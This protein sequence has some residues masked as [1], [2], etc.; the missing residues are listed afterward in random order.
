MQKFSFNHTKA[1]RHG[2]ICYNINDAYVGQSFHNYGEFSEGEVELFAQM[3]AEGDVVI[4]AGANI[5]AHTLWFARH[6]G[7]KGAVFAF[8]PQR[9]VYQLLC[10][11]MA[12]NSIVNAHCFNVALGP[13]PG[14]VVVPVI[15]PTQ[16][17]NFGGLNIEG[18]A[19]GEPVPLVRLDSFDVPRLKLIKVDVEGMEQK[20]LEGATGLIARFRP[21]LYVE[22]DRS[23][24]SNALIKYIDSLGYNMFWHRPMLF[25]PKNFA[26]NP[27]NMFGPVA[28]INMLCIPKEIQANMQGFEAVQVPA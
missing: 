14:Q 17:N 11:N 12:L 15:D 6:V 7:I 16:P 9:L 10:A 27:T 1:C 18:H 3:I 19:R 5:G 22:N 20:V 26:N 2:L 8:E 25:N 28:S 21:L 24:Q 13:A 23:A 4:E